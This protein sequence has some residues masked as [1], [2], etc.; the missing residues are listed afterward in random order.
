MKVIYSPASEGHGLG[1]NY[2]CAEC[3]NWIGSTLLGRLEHPTTEMP[4]KCLQT[5]KICD[6]PKH[7]IEAPEKKP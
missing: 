3:G 4:V 5:G 2:Y 7:E 1:F 6:L